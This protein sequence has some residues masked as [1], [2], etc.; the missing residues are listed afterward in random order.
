MAAFEQR[1]NSTYRFSSN[2]YQKFP[3]LFSVLFISTN[4]CPCVVLSIL[5]VVGQVGCGKSSLLLS[6][7][8]EVRKLKGSII[9]GGKL[10]FVP[11]Q[12]W[13]QN[14]TL[15]DN[16]LFGRPFDQEL[17]DRVV[18]DCALEADIAL[19]PAG[20]ETEIGER[21]IN[22][23]GGQKQRVSLARAAYSQ[24]SIVVLDDPLSS[25]DGHVARHIFERVI[26]PEG[27]LRNSTRLFA[28]N[29][30]ACLPACDRV[31]LLGNDGRLLLCDTY[32]ALSKTSA[33]AAFV[34]AACSDAPGP[35]QPPC[36][37]HKDQAVTAIRQANQE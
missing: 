3:V 24:A 20:H 18:A 5:A 10:A 27:C 35:R 37:Q 11:Q 29:S 26:G 1:D 34:G 30:L 13:L 17:Y 14:A 19:L 6:L 8:S 12:A 15:R 2:N 23:S 31:L 33:F 36:Q 16:I 25:V 7:F 21:G 28:T 32:A 22:L 4:P 9:V